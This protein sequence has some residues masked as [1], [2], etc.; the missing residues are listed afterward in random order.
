MKSRHGTIGYLTLQHSSALKTILLFDY[1][2]F[3]LLSKSFGINR[4]QGSR[5]YF[6]I[7]Y[8]NVFKT[9][10]AKHEKTCEV[11][12]AVFHGE[13]LYVVQ[14]YPRKRKKRNHKSFVS[15]AKLLTSGDIE[16]NPGPV[17]QGN[18]LNNLNELLQSRLAPHGLRILGVGGASDCYFRV[19][20]HQWNAET[21]YR[22]NVC[23]TGIH[24]H[25]PKVKR[26]TFGMLKK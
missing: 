22:V 4:V 19:V 2:I 1:T 7:D 10:T 3:N 12:V 14:C 13:F 5:L 17:T 21:S 20:S 9:R 25:L 15:R 16:L 18:N 11:S 24:L 26:V 23:S 6:A 8:V